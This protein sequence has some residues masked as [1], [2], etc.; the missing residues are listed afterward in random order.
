MSRPVTVTVGPLTAGSASAIALSQTPAAAANL[1]LNGTLVVGGVAVL[2][3]PRRVLISSVSN[4]S[5]KTFIIYGTNNGGNAV[6]ESVTGPNATGALSVLDYATVTRIAAS[7]ATSGAITAGTSNVASSA[8]VWLNHHG[9]TQVSMQFNTSGT[10][11]YTV[12]ST[13]DDIQAAP[14]LAVWYNH[15]TV[16][17]ATSGTQDNYAYKPEAIKV[18][19][20]SGSGSV[21][22]DIMQ[23]GLANN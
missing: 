3:K 4:E 1:T 23:T 12:Q 7:A 16:A 17:A 19:L 21:T 2:D 10:V 6:S 22:A 9:L 14:Q 20:N 13:L 8:W 15:P 18:T 11:N 5:T